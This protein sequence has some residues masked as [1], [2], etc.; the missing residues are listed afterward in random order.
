MVRFVNAVPGESPLV[1]FWNESSATPGTAYRSVSQFMP[2]P[3][4]G[5]V[6][7]RVRGGTSDSTVADNS[8]ML[9]NEGHYTVVA[10]PGDSGAVRLTIWRDDVAD[11]S[12]RG[13][14]RLLNATRDANDVR[15]IIDGE[16]D[17][18]FDDIDTGRDGDV[19]NV[20][21][22]SAT[23][24]I[25]RTGMAKPVRI[26]DLLRSGG[27][28]HSLIVSGTAAA[29]DVITL[30]DDVVRAQA[31]LRSAPDTADRHLSDTLTRQP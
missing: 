23:I 19:K 30:H 27:S 16:K 18:V 22:G 26:A 1:L 24:T 3:A 29:M 17:P 14:L 28:T 6:H 2:V 9:R 5:P 7:F 11:D 4:A 20:A 15:V 31:R 21:P 12:T 13:R 25:T 8:E 10:V